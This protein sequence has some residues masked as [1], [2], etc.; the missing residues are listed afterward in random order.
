MSKV[1]EKQDFTKLRRGAKYWYD[2]QLLEY[3]KMIKG[4]FRFKDA[5]GNPVTIGK[6][7]YD[8]ITPHP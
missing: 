4:S 1:I 5:L 7:E 3:S 8:K 2:G 6:S